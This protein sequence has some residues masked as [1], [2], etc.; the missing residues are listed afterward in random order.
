MHGPMNTMPSPLS[1]NNCNPSVE[2]VQ[3]CLVSVRVPH[4]IPCFLMATFRSWP[5][6]TEGHVSVCFVGWPKLKVKT[7]HDARS[8]EQK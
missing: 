1:A 7:Q 4:P 6:R 5:P 3:S 8:E 2:S